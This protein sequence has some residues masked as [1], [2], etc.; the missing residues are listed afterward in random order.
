MLLEGEI[1]VITGAASERG[2]GQGIAKLFSEHGAKVA[3]FD[4]D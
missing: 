1:A 3:I 4:L 2:L